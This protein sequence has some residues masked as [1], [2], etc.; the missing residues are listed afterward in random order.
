MVT[1]PK[2]RPP[3]GGEAGER[4]GAV[5]PDE[6]AALFERAAQR[7]WC[8]AVGIVGDAAQAEDIVQEAAGIALGKLG[9]FD[10]GTSFNAWM[11]QIVRFVAMNERRRGVRQRTRPV[12]P[13]AFAEREGRDGRVMAEP[14]DS[15]G[16][17][18]GDQGAFDDGLTAAL[19]ELGETARACLLLRTILELTYEE[20]ADVLG[21]PQ[22]TAM[23]HVHRSRQ[24]LRVALVGRAE[25]RTR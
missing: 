6:F 8:V 1:R 20:I 17:L 24:T 19:G 2:A 15:R 21:I 23:S 16:R 14:V 18:A 9:Q 25:G 5:S 3:V 13:A 12:D 7:L 11:G 22:G 4:G 10:R